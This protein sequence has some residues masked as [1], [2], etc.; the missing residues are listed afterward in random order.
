M[1][2]RELTVKELQEEVAT[3]ETHNTKI[4]RHFEKKKELILVLEEEN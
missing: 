2:K 4:S 3:L 1:A